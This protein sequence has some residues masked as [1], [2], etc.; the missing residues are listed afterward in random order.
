MFK[1]DFENNLEYFQNMSKEDYLAGILNF[2][3]QELFS[4]NL[5]HIYSVT[6]EEERKIK[7]ESTINYIKS[8]Y[9]DF[10]LDE[11]K[12]KPENLLNTS[13]FRGIYFAKENDEYA[14]NDA[15]FSELCDYI[16]N[17]SLSYDEL[18]SI[19]LNPIMSK[20]NNGETLSSKEF[21]ILSNY[22]KNNS[23]GFISID[24]A[25]NMIKN[26][27]LKINHIFEEDV[28]KEIVRSLILDYSNTSHI[29]YTVEFVHVSDNFKGL[30]FHRINPNVIILK[31]ALIT[32]FIS[33]N[34]VELI[35]CFFYE[36]S[37]IT[38]ASV[39][40]KNEI[41]Y[42]TLRVIMGLINERVDL[43]KIFVSLDYEPYSY[44]ADLKTSA[45]VKTLRFYQMLGIDL[46]DNYIDNKIMEIPKNNEIEIYIDKKS[47]ST[48]M[49]FTSKFKKLDK[50]K[51][52]SYISKFKVL[53]LF[54]NK[55]G[56]KKRTIDLIKKYSNG[57]YREILGTYLCS[58]IIEPEEMCEDVSDLVNFKS[59]D[60]DVNRLVEKLLKYIYVDSIYYSLTSYINLNKT[61]SNFNAKE[62]LDDMIVRINCIKDTPITHRYID[63]ALITIED[64]KQ[65]L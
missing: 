55:D 27:A 12:K 60:E 5:Y 43:D 63:K 33:G 10:L 54:Y 50:D 14:R 34:Y 57:E 38:N 21:D 40:E 37:I 23:K 8:F 48:D 56:E 51:I 24:L 7:K 42:K 13:F 9:D 46:F 52:Q 17:K 45:F 4:K 2:I 15:M 32:K 53:G 35:N 59:K 64:M 65:N 25:L 30:S 11:F 19:I 36:M 28:V 31:E 39:L 49:M 1:N 62:Y 47:I 3:E 20:L 41:S 44:F 61:R 58:R 29:K 18:I 26:H 22:I 16:F 6:S